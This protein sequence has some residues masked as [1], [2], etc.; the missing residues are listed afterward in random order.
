[1]AID[2]LETIGRAI[3]KLIGA[4]QLC[5]R[6]DEKL[7]D[8]IIEKN[9]VYSGLELLCASMG[10]YLHDSSPYFYVSPMPGFGPFCYTNEELRKAMNYNFRNEDMYTALFIISVIVTE[11]YP[12]AGREQAVSF[13]R[14]ND[15]I[16][17]VDERI[18]GL[19][20]RVDLDSISYDNSYNFELVVKK[21][22]ELPTVRP[23]KNDPDDV[24]TRGRASK[25]QIINTTLQFLNEQNLINIPEDVNQDKFIYITDRFK[26]TVYNIYRLGS[27]QS[28]IYNLIEGLK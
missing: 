7:Y 1:M 9:E 24:R 19:K 27:A 28:D 20:D 6:D 3:S 8:E 5:R 2:A 25:L 10:L 14:L 15:V 13:I 16:R 23:D 12:E 21:W 26:A 18:D 22:L 4:G 11:F 17:L